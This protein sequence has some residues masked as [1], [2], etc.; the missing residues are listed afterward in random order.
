MQLKLLILYYILQINVI[1]FIKAFKIP[2]DNSKEEINE[3]Y[4]ECF[5]YI[6]QNNIDKNSLIQIYDT[7]DYDITKFIKFIINNNN[8]FSIN[9]LC[10]KNVNNNEKII[11]NKNKVFYHKYGRIN[12][13]IIHIKYKNFESFIKNL[14]L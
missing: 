1:F 11:I 2:N 12:F 9:K 13:I 6:Y 7:N 4:F 3:N 10:D 5:K 14:R 8:N